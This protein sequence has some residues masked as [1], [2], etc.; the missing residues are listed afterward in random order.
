MLYDPSCEYTCIYKYCIHTKKQQNVNTCIDTFYIVSSEKDQTLQHW[1]CIFQNCKINCAP[2]RI[3]PQIS[4]HMFISQNAKE[5]KQKLPS[6]SFP[7]TRELQ[8]GK[9][10]SFNKKYAVPQDKHLLP[11]APFT[12]MK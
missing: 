9:F 7:F 4:T 1:H 8:V 11:T 12:P 10:T 3:H 5:C 2:C 6:G